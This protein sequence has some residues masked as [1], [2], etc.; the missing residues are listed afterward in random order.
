[1]AVQI[2]ISTNSEPEFLLVMFFSTLNFKSFKRIICLF[3]SVY[4]CVCVCVCVY[5]HMIANA[6]ERYRWKIL[7]GTS[8]HGCL[9]QNQSLLQEDWVLLS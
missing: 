3:Q 9:E 6:C 4:V 8:W 1:M 5:V 7:L 2:C